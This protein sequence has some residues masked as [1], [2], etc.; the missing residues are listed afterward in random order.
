M[1]FPKTE[2]ERSNELL[3]NVYSDLCGKTETKSLSG[4]EYFA[5]FI[6]DKSRFT[7]WKSIDSIDQLLRTDNGGECTS[8]EFK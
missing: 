7:D 5:F 3:G 8:K 6:N 4:A 1:P 2:G